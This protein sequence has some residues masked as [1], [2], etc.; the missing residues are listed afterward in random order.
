MQGEPGAMR[1]MMSGSPPVCRQRLMK[2][3]IGALQV[4]RKA[5]DTSITA[6][7]SNYV[8]RHPEAVPQYVPGTIERAA[9]RRQYVRDA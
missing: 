5:Q 1:A 3:W 2:S 9:L 8:R 7:A 4:Q 6:D